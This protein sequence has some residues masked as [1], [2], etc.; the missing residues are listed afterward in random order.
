MNP[1]ALCLRGSR[2]RGLPRNPAGE[3]KPSLAVA[4]CRFGIKSDRAVPQFT[5]YRTT[6]AVSNINALTVS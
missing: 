5:N 1:P 4:T 2:R 3:R 6:F